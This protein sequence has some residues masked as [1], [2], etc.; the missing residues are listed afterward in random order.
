MQFIFE[1]LCTLK[2]GEEGLF[3]IFKK[4]SAMVT[5]GALLWKGT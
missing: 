1:V 2:M 5:K 3:K 4:S